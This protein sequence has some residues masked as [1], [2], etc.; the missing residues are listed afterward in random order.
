MKN[1]GVLKGRALELK[2]DDDADP[3]SEVLV[4]ASGKKSR[5]AINVRSSRGPLATRL[6]EYLLLP[7]LTHPLLDHARTLKEGFTDLRGPQQ[8][9]RSS[10]PSTRTSPE[11]MC[12]EDAVAGREEGN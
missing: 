5:I 3:H 10:T 8:D 2:R 7:D 12:K 4:L 11:I 6:I 1:Y 9:D